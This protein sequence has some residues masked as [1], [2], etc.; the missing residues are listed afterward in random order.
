MK[1]THTLIALLLALPAYA[2][3]QSP[4]V[5]PPQGGAPK[6]TAPTP[7]SEEDKERAEVMKLI[8]EMESTLKL[9]TDSHVQVTN[10]KQ[11]FEQL[12]QGHV[13][14]TEREMLKTNQY[15]RKQLTTEFREL[16]ARAKSVKSQVETSVIPQQRGVEK[17][18]EARTKTESDPD[19]K[20]KIQELLGRQAKT[21]G[22]TEEQVKRLQSNIDGLTSAITI[23]EGQLSYL[24]LVEESLGMGEKVSEQLRQLNKEID[25]VVNTL[26]EREM[27]R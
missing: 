20:L 21:I 10:I 6:D 9:I 17:K 25:R 5:P 18:L 15:M 19:L 13:K 23:L 4:Q 24:D 14:T 12:D 26:L 27:G 16:R 1:I 11:V 8:T 2:Q 3:R 7:E 22:E